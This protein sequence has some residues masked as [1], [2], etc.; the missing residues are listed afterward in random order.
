ML[1]VPAFSFTHSPAASSSVIA[2]G[3]NGSL[4]SFVLGYPAKSACPI[5]VVFFLEPFLWE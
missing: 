4:L 3:G 1:S 5:G 2:K